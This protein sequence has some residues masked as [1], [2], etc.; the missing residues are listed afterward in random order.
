[1]SDDGRSGPARASANGLE[2]FVRSTLRQVWRLA[3]LVV[4]LTV[5]LI[6]LIMFV[7]PG[8]GLVVLPLG[9][10]ILAIEFVWARR[11]LHQVRERAAKVRND[12]WRSDERGDQQ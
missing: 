3:V 7:T 9:L 8:P 11:L 4:G 12:Y 10:A 6:G 1:M 5:A 2:I